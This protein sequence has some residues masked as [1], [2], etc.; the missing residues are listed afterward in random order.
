MTDIGVTIAVVVSVVSLIGT[1]TTVVR[2]FTKTEVK[3]DNLDTLGKDT[4]RLARETA[5]KLKELDALRER[6]NGIDERLAKTTRTADDTA[7]R[8]VREGQTAHI[9]LMGR[10]ATLERDMAKLA[11]IESVQ[12][13]RTEVKMGFDEVKAMLGRIERDMETRA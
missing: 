5:D 2:L 6:V 10:V 8:F 13:V 3:A 1:I 7:D 9:A 4:A 11:T 12:A